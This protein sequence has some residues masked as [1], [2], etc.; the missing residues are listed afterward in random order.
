MH[1]FVFIAVSSA[2]WA[3][4]DP[5]YTTFDGTYYHFMGIC[6]YVLAKDRNNLFEIR[7]VNE[8]CGN[9]FVSCTLSLSVMIPGY[10]VILER[11]RVEVNGLTVLLP[12]NYL[13]KNE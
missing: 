3:T 12:V 8:P 11:N 1:Q 10:V 5:H 9:G 13:G 7:Q 2:C 6:E 4:G